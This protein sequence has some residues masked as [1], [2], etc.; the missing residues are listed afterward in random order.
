MLQNI[1]LEP[2]GQEGSFALSSVHC[3]EH[4]GWPAMSMV[5]VQTW[6]SQ[7]GLLVLALTHSMPNSPGPG[8]CQSG[9]GPVVAAKADLARQV[10]GRREV[11]HEVGGMA[12]SE[13]A[14]LPRETDLARPGRRAGHRD[15]AP[16]HLHGRRDLQTAGRR[17]ELFDLGEPF[18]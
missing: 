15:V 3:W 5:S 6:L 14:F 16:D 9:A 18:I 17:D 1:P 12:A 2:F 10:G 7:S 4:T 11:G 8:P 13:Q